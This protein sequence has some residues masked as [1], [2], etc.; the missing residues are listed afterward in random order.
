MDGAW[1]AYDEKTVGL[2]GYNLDGFPTASEN[3]VEGIGRLWVDVM[4]EEGAGDAGR[5]G[6]GAPT[7][8]TSDWR[9]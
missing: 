7:A 1:A 9:S 8:G 5:R 3:S 2:L 4:S 6:G